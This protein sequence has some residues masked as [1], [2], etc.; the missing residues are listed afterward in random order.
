MLQLKKKEEILARRFRKYLDRS[1]KN[2]DLKIRETE[3]AFHYELKIPGYVKEDFNFYFEED[4]LVVTTDKSKNNV[5]ATGSRHSYCY[6]SAYFKRRIAVPDVIKK[7]V[8]MVDYKD[9]VLSF[10]LLK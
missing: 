9:E 2:T 8:A 1:P 10:D 3:A 6:P 4:H 7:D 5:E